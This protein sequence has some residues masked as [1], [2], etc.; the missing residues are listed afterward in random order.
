MPTTPT[1]DDAIGRCFGWLM[2]FGL[3]KKPDFEFHNKRL[4]ILMRDIIGKFQRADDYLTK[5]PNSLYQIQSAKGAI[6]KAHK[7][8]GEGKKQEGM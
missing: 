5:D 4:F 1:L 3:F 6:A 2:V 8:L 7:Q